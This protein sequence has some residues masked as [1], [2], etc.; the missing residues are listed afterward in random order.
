MSAATRAKR[1]HDFYYRGLPKAG[2]EPVVTAKH[3]GDAT[4]NALGQVRTNQFMSGPG[5]H[6][7]WLLRQFHVVKDSGKLKFIPVPVA[8][9]PPAS[10]FDQTINQPLGNEFR[11][12]FLSQVSVLADQSKCDPNFKIDCISMETASQFDDG[13]SEEGGPGATVP[14]PMDFAN[15]FKNSPS[16]RAE[17][18]AKIPAGSAL[19]PDDIVSRAQTQTCAGC[20][21]FSVNASL[22]GGMVWPSTLPPTFTHEQL[23]SPES[24]PDG[25]R[26]QISDALK[27]VFLPFRKHVIETFLQ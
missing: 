6:G 27:N 16:F 2:V 17:I 9:N 18:Q 19:T 26:Y 1:L 13:E 21:H 3:Y 5:S 8:T 25:L 7:P 22:G 12:D 15:A 11:Q 23:A 20:H 14:P 10:L 24:G 4:K